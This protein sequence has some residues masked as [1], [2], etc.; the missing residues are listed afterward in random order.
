MILSQF[1]LILFCDEQGK[2]RTF[3]PNLR[4]EEFVS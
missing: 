3:S 4:M 1:N 2:I